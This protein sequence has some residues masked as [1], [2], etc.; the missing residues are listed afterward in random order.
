M[1]RRVSG[2]AQ[3]FFTM[4][5]KIL[6]TNDRTS[7]DQSLSGNRAQVCFDG[8]F[9]GRERLYYGWLVGEF[10]RRGSRAAEC[11]IVDK[12]AE[13]VESR[14]EEEV[15]SLCVCMTQRW[16]MMQREIRTCTQTKISAREPAHTS[17]TDTRDSSPVWPLEKLV[18]AW[19]ACGYN[20][21]KGKC[22]T[23]TVLLVMLQLY[24]VHYETYCLTYYLPTLEEG[25]LNSFLWVFP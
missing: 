5:R 23:N 19:T 12:W 7:N 17:S 1:L 10:Q 16:A 6:R 8:G 2:N 14:E 18:P 24:S 13:G 3:T 20:R 4:H 21:K 22:L 15:R 25:V 11:P 9:K